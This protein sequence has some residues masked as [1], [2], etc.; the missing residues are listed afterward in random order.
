MNYVGNG[1]RMRVLEEK[2]ISMKRT[3]KRI[4]N[5]LK[6]KRA[7]PIPP[8][9]LELLKVL[10]KESLAL[11]KAKF[12]AESESSDDTSSFSETNPEDSETNTE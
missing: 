6:E 10:R 5:F 3:H 4:K 12:T 7:A 9:I 8:E 2:S 11:K 1:D